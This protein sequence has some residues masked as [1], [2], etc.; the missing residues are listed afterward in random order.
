[1]NFRRGPNRVALLCI[2]EWEAF[3]AWQEGRDEDREI[4]ERTWPC[5]PGRKC[6][7]GWE[8]S[9]QAKREEEKAEAQTQ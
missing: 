4:G 9:Q 2:I 3:R 5:T 6:T 8:P 7:S 1:M